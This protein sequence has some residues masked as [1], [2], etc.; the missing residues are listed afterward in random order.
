[1]K[2]WFLDTNVLI[3]FLLNRPPFAMDAATLLELAERRE[4]QLYVASLSFAT[5][6]YLGRKTRPHQQTIAVLANLAQLVQIV[7]V[8]AIVVRQ[9]LA[10]GFSDF[11]DALQHFTATA[12]PA[13][14]AIITRDPKGFQASTLPVLTPQEALAEIK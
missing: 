5:A 7:S 4:V 13:I 6:Y 2:H 10:A 8:D 1:M 11:E 9:A 3:D 14:E 12:V